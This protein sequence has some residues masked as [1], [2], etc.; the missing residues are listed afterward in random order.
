MHKYYNRI[1]QE[2]KRHAMIVFPPPRELLM[3]GAISQSDGSHP[4]LPRDFNLTLHK[5]II[6]LFLLWELGQPQL[7][8]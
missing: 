1:I 4:S 5:R 8:N 3:M 6:I 7:Q 2:I